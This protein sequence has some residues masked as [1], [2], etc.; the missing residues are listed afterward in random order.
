MN[1]NPESTLGLLT[2]AGPSIRLL[3]SPSRD[4]TKMFAVMHNLPLQGSINIEAG[5]KVATVSFIRHWL[6]NLTFNLKLALK[7]RENKAGSARIIVF[8]SSPVAS[9][10]NN[11][12]KL[13]KSLRKSN[14]R[15]Y[16]FTFVIADMQRC[17]PTDCS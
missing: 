16:S 12:V 4:D 13:G 15:F 11:L 9:S 7:H 1:D 8:A 3:M 2:M 14:V 10:E 6:C 17:Q 5:I